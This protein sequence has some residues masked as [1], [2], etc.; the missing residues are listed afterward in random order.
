MAGGSGGG[1]Q[2]GVIGSAGGGEGVEVD[3]GEFG[4]ALPTYGSWLNWIEAEFAALRYFALNGTDH[5]SHDEQN[6]VI[7]A[8]VGWRNA[9][10]GQKTA[11]APDSPIRSWTAGHQVQ[12]PELVDT[13]HSTVGGRSVVQR[14]VPGGGGLPGDLAGA[15]DP[16]QGLPADGRGHLL[17]AQV[18]GKLAQ[19]PGGELQ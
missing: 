9:R 17:L 10:A 15:Q 13:Y 11:F 16:A 6:A 7:A 8:Y 2:V 5:R 4:F 12:R 3:G 18:L 14:Q 1:V 19:A